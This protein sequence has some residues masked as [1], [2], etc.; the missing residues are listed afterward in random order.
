MCRFVVH[1]SSDAS[2][3]RADTATAPFFEIAQS[4]EPPKAPLARRRQCVGHYTDEERVRHRRCQPRVPLPNRQPLEKHR[5]EARL[6]IFESLVAGGRCLHRRETTCAARH[7]VHVHRCG[8]DQARRVVVPLE[9]ANG[10]GKGCEE[11]RLAGA[12]RGRYP[13]CR[14]VR[15]VA[16]T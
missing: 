13:H 11:P 1:A 8:H 4:S 2:G 9:V 5:I 14:A 15:L 10:N 12:G 3:G 16:T 7:F 6:V